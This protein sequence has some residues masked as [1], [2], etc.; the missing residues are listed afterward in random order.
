MLISIAEFPLARL[1]L[2][3][4][5]IYS[6]KIS[7]TQCPQLHQIQRQQPGCRNQ[8]PPPWWPVNFVQIF[9]AMFFSPKKQQTPTPPHQ[10]I[11]NPPDGRGKRLS[12]APWGN[13][14]EKWMRKQILSPKEIYL[15]VRMMTYHNDWRIRGMYIHDIKNDL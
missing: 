14:G 9:G 5:D 12:L 1:H 3:F 4:G 13:R 8:G 11:S 2:S 15:N 6:S 10:R 7:F